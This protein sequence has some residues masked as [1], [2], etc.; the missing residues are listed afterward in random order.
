MVAD[1]LASEP[2]VVLA[3]QQPPTPPARD[4]GI[5][6]PSNLTPL[7]YENTPRLLKPGGKVST[8]MEWEAKSRTKGPLVLGTPYLLQGFDDFAGF[9]D[10]LGQA[11]L[12]F[13]DLGIHLGFYLRLHDV[14]DR[15]LKAHPR[16]NPG[17]GG[18]AIGNGKPV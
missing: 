16:Q 7:G 18:V 3:S 1:G 2:P 5:V 8:K 14:V 13:V 15:E 17:P 10:H 12:L 11:H 4:S 9:Q 6:R